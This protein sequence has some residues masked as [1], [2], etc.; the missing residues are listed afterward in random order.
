MCFNIPCPCLAVVNTLFRIIARSE[1]LNFLF[2]QSG[3]GL[4][5]LG[6]KIKRI[7]QKIDLTQEEVASRCNLSKGF[8]SQVERDIT[9]PSIATLVDILECLGTNLKDFFN[10]PDNQKIVFGADDIFSLDNTEIASSISWLIPNAQKNDMEPILLTLYTN[11]KSPV[12]SPFSGEVFGYVSVGTVI[13][14]VGGNKHKV[15]KGESF[16]FKANA[17]FYL[18]NN[19]KGEAK[20]VF[21]SSPPNF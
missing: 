12:Y 21:V 15:K 4:V 17:E 5:E 20:I 1:T 16:Y 14:F 19:T 18:E 13:L 6:A 7:R 11:G 10:E 2:T 8:I 3:G 9:S